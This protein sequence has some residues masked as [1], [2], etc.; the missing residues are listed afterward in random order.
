MNV[1]SMNYD[2]SE[3]RKAFI[4][5]CEQKIDEAFQEKEDKIPNARWTL[6]ENMIP[7]WSQYK[8]LFNFF[9]GEQQK[10][11][12]ICFPE[13]FDVLGHV[14]S[15]L[16]NSNQNKLK[17]NLI[18]PEW[19]NL[20]SLIRSFN[21]Y[22]IFENVDL[23]YKIDRQ[24][25]YGV[26]SN[27][28]LCRL[29]RKD[30]IEVNM[31]KL[32][33]FQKYNNTPADCCSICPYF[34]NPESIH[35]S[36]LHCEF[37]FRDLHNHNPGDIE[38]LFQ[39]RTR[40]P[41]ETF[42]RYNDDVKQNHE[43]NILIRITT[44]KSFFLCLRKRSMLYGSDIKNMFPN[45]KN[46]F[47]GNQAYPDYLMVS[48]YF[49][50]KLYYPININ[51]LKNLDVFVDE[52]LKKFFT[53]FMKFL[54]MKLKDDHFINTNQSTDTN[55]TIDTNEPYDIPIVENNFFN[56]TF[57]QFYSNFLKFP[58]DLQLFLLNRLPLFTLRNNVS[59]SFSSSINDQTCIIPDSYIQIISNHFQNDPNILELH[60]KSFDNDYNTEMYKLF[61]QF[62][63]MF[64]FPENF[65]FNWNSPIMENEP[66]IFG[67]NVIRMDYNMM[68]GVRILS[69]YPQFYYEWKNFLVNRKP[70]FTSIYLTG[71][72]GI[73]KSSI[74]PYLLLRWRDDSPIK[75]IKNQQ[76]T[77]KML[78]LKFY[79]RSPVD[80]LLGQ[81]F[82]FFYENVLFIGNVSRTDEND[83]NQIITLHFSDLLMIKSF[84]A[85]SLTK[86]DLNNPIIKKANQQIKQ[87][88]QIAIKAQIIQI[89][90][91]I[92]T[93]NDINE[94]D[95]PII[96]FIEDRN[97]IAFVYHSDICNYLTI[98]D[99]N[100][101]Y[102]TNSNTI[103]CSSFCNRTAEESIER[104][105]VAPMCTANEFKNILLLI[106]GYDKNRLLKF[107]KSLGKLINFNIRKV[108]FYA[109]SEYPI[110]DI[111]RDILTQ[112]E[113]GVLRPVNM[114]FI[115]EVVND[116]NLIFIIAPPELVSSHSID[117]LIQFTSRESY[118]ALK[119]EYEAKFH[120][121]TDSYSVILKSLIFNRSQDEFLFER[122]VRY[123]FS[124][125]CVF[126][127]K[128]VVQYTRT[129]PRLETNSFNLMVSACNEVQIA[130]SLNELVQKCD[131][132]NESYCIFKPY[133]SQPFYDIALVHKSQ[134]FLFQVT[135]SPKHSFD[136]QQLSKIL[137]TH[138]INPST[139]E[140][141]FNRL[142]II[143]ERDLDIPD[144]S[145]FIVGDVCKFLREHPNCE[146][147]CAQLN[148]DLT[149]AI[150][151]QLNKLR[152]KYLENPEVIDTEMAKLCEACNANYY[153][154]E[155]N[156]K[157]QNTG[158]YMKNRSQTQDEV[159]IHFPITL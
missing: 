125:P 138:C 26:N 150:R 54:N 112:A 102:Q 80:M 2:L 37:H 128:K 46:I 51:Q 89:C 135:A 130:N 86:N 32:E 63:T 8:N 28:P 77:G 78:L 140:F 157:P 151:E 14:L 57:D 129:S 71:S 33:L 21:K 126:T 73:G 116:K 82:Y 49:Q 117:N 103:V 17:I 123:N 36:G 56:L 9:N 5:N 6:V 24:D 105:F 52:P 144:D 68:Y 107:G 67:K 34:L 141:Y 64:L 84:K 136:Q 152:S 99:G 146:I 16:L 87:C 143:Y 27:Y 53:E 124:S 60:S 69:W 72:P 47:F 20:S 106:Q 111:K 132:Q 7:N 22:N 10:P 75:F 1:M 119:D 4:L 114:S 101:S 3:Q 133:S 121:L 31:D 90:E 42:L 159:D 147:L 97:S 137:K 83:I 19:C 25:S 50:S 30:I 76:F 131:P 94:N 98:V 70:L 55:L 38:D 95:V 66:N 48:D 155:I 29:K 149:I 120:R 41:V 23:E 81:I 92:D 127:C 62:V 61:W 109:A 85:T 104:F 139:N 154:K 148:S 44:Q 156:P 74:I 110:E 96:G 93:T 118:F 58:V 88:F 134:L 100:V 40:C 59:N 122:I 18:L 45:E 153:Q 113:S 65:Q 91:Y 145:S 43:K 142:T 158:S 11:M 15:T 13:D 12:R 39:G 115:K 79:K 35:D 108:I